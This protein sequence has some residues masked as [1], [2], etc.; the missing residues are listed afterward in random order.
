MP[1]KLLDVTGSVINEAPIDFS[2]ISFDKVCKCTRCG[3]Q[4]NDATRKLRH[5]CEVTVCYHC[6]Q[7]YSALSRV[8]G[9][10]ATSRANPTTRSVCSKHYAEERNSK[11]NVLFNIFVEVMQLTDCVSC[12]T[13]HLTYYKSPDLLHIT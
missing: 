8:K 7:I 1:L 10:K 13:N 11:A 2:H 4:L 5:R 12:N 3:M 9:E 6:R